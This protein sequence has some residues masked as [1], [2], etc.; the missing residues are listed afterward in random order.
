[1]DKAITSVQMGFVLAPRINAAGRMG[2]ADWPPT[3]CYRDRTR[4]RPPWPASCATSTGS[5]R[6]WSRT[7][8]AQAVDRSTT[9]RR[10]SAALWC[11]P[12]SDV[13]PGGGGHRGLP[14]VGKIRL[15]QLYDPPARRQWARAP[16]AA[17]AAST[18]SPLWSAAPTCWW[19]SAATSWRRA[20][21]S[22]RSNIPAFRQR[23]NRCVREYGGGAPVVL[24]GDGCRPH[25]PRGGH[26]GRRWRRWG[27]WSPTAPATTARCSALMGATVERLQSVGQNRHLKLRLS[28]GSSQF[29]AIFFSVTAEQCGVA[30]GS[31]V[32]AAFYLQINEFRGNRTRT[33]ADDGHP[34]LPQP[35]PRRRSAWTCWSAVAGRP[36]PAQEAVRLLPSREQFVRLWRC[37]GAHRPPAGT[38]PPAT[39]R[40]CGSWPRGWR[41]ATPSCA[42]LL[43]GGLRGAGAADPPA[44]DDTCPAL[45]GRE[46]VAGGSG[47]GLHEVCSP[48]SDPC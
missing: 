5:A 19:I 26:P 32:D 23:M 6:R 48:R 13:A 27:C 14:P 47:K 20:S 40:C 29:D 24:P 28:K 9:C 31:R 18:F 11:W 33:A 17:G 38:R 25:L 45:T 22:G 16:A 44:E 8:Y 15:S 21:P 41:R 43:S 10:R 7:I 34:P 42:R 36:A 3:S 30:P 1:M 46:H 39:C 4:R 37:A 2:A 12:P 35:Q